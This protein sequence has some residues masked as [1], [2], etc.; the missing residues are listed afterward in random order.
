M[1]Y[2]YSRFFWERT[3]TFLGT[4]EV[5]ITWDIP[6]DVLPGVYRITYFGHSRN[7]FGSVSAFQ[8]VTRTFTVVN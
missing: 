1:R 6:A 4:S 7:I 5:E 3:S 2:T 8:G